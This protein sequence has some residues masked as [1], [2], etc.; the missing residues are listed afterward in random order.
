RCGYAIDVAGDGVDGLRQARRGVYD[1]IVLDLNLP[2]LDGLSV[3]RTLRE[4]GDQT[5]VLILTARGRVD[6]RVTGLRSGADDYL[7]KPFAFDELV[8]RIEALVRRDYGTKNPAIT[9]GPLVVD[10][11]ARTVVRDGAAVT[12]ARREYALLEYLAHRKGQVV[13]RREIEDHL[14]GDAEFPMSN[15]VDRLVCGLRKKIERGPQRL[16]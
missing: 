16:L 3:L 6:D 5:H 9:I 1:V 10:T 15:A 8:A 14:Y 13:D 7:G 2:E 12:L 4:E 11:G